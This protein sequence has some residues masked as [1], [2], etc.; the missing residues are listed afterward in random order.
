MLN[1]KTRVNV[2]VTFKDKINYLTLTLCT[3]QQALKGEGVWVKTF[4][5]DTGC[6]TK[7]P[8]LIHRIPNSELHKAGPFKSIAAMYKTIIPQVFKKVKQEHL[9]II[10]SDAIVH[11]NIFPAI[12]QMIQDLPDMGYGSVFNTPS[13]RVIQRRGIY[14]RKNTLGFFGSI[15]RRSLWTFKTKGGIDWIYG[16]HVKRKGYKI[17]CTNRSYIEHMGFSGTHRRR[18]D[19]SVNFLN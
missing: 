15:I 12:R 14:L 11:P 18:V 3:L 16:A 4:L 8:P 10:E 19:R 1:T 17:Y 13:H 9:V 6:K 5:Y 7:L 2:L